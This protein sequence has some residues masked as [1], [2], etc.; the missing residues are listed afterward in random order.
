MAS[1]VLV[2]GVGLGSVLANTLA[3]AGVGKLRLVD[4]DF[5]EL[6][7]LQRQVLFDES[8][9]TANLPKAIAAAEKL[10]TINSEH[11]IE[12]IVADVGPDNIAS[13]CDGVDLIVDGTDNFSNRRFLLNDAAAKFGI[14]WVYGGC[15]SRRPNDDDR[16]RRDALPA[17]RDGRAAPAG[18]FAYLRNGLGILSPIINVIASIEAMEAIKI[19]AGKREAI[20]RGSCSS[21]CGTTRSEP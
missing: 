2:C 18:L 19:L 13:L 4:R 12:P 9:V 8:D 16:P 20:Q 6:N 21:I 14:P 5:V 1:R 10:R 3:R 15:I 7:N 17:P 11:Q